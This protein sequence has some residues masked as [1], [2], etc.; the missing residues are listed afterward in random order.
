MSIVDRLRQ[1]LGGASRRDA[2][3]SQDTGASPVHEDEQITCR[4]ALRVV[5][6]FIDGELE[7]GSETRIRQHFD[8]CRR[9]YPHLGFER[10]FRD[11]IRRATADEAAPERLRDRVAA[12]IAEAESED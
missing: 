4:E 8:M 2:S 9:C 3:E 7:A 12:L 6:E 11:A 1:L 5:Q 10:A